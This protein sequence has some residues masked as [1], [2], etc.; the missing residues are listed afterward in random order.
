MSAKQRRTAED[1]FTRYIVEVND[2]DWSF[3]FGLQRG[4]RSAEPYADYRHLHIEGIIK[5]PSGEGARSAHLI[6]MPDASLDRQVWSNKVT[7]H[8]GTLESRRGELHGLIGL[9]ENALESVLLMMVSGRLRYVDLGGTRLSR[10]QVR[11]ENYRLSRLLDED[12]CPSRPPHRCLQRHRQCD[13]KGHESQNPALPEQRFAGLR[14]H[15]VP[16]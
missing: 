4:R 7:R 6:F 14:A 3:S 16:R 2:W 1:K 10:N 12:A 15:C 9:P 5:L 11:L 13:S 8:I